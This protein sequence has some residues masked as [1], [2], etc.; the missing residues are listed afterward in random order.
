MSSTTA[1]QQCVMR[2]MP[3]TAIDNKSLCDWPEP[4]LSTG[5]GKKAI[6]DEK[7]LHISTFDASVSCDWLAGRN[8]CSDS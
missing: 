6:A 7:S 1:K 5:H 8:C 4:S 2:S 3:K